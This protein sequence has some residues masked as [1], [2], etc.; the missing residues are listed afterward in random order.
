LVLKDEH[1]DNSLFAASTLASRPAGDD[2]RNVVAT[3][4]RQSLLDE[5]EGGVSGTLARD[6]GASIGVDAMV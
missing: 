2:R 1:Q 6:N 5:L 3:P 4:A